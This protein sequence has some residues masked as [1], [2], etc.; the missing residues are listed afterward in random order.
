MLYDSLRK[1]G[2]QPLLFWCEEFSKGKS[3]YKHFRNTSALALLS[4]ALT[5]PLAATAGGYGA[6]AVRDGNVA[7]T[8]A[9]ATV[10]C[11]RLG[12]NVPANLAAQMDCGSATPR[13]AGERVRN[14]GG[15]LFGGHQVGSAPPSNNDGGNIVSVVRDRSTSDGV[16][17]DDDGNPTNG[18]TDGGNGPGDG[19]NSPNDGGDGPGDGGSNPTDGNGPKT[20]TERLNELGLSLGDVRNQSQ[21]FQDSFNDF[22]GNNGTRGD[23]SDFNP[24]D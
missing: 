6:S 15:G 19:G 20:K 9:G 11:A 18:P 22:V 3:M 21:G 5:L 10:P 12:Q 1:S 4:V 16:S 17:S 2:F 14:T 8:T 7:N 13:V 23:W 24:P